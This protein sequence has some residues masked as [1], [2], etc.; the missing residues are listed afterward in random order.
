MRD[1]HTQEW[2][3]QMATRAATLA[4]PQVGYTPAA[5]K[6]PLVRTDALYAETDAAAL[7][8]DWMERC[9]VS[10]ASA[11]DVL[12]EI[13]ICEHGDFVARAMHLLSNVGIFTNRDKLVQALVE[14]LED[15]LLKC[16]RHE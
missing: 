2:R 6:G 8:Y 3:E 11:Q 13:E 10:T 5:D 15:T 14:S 16:A 9:E 1:N 12:K 4:T 7:A